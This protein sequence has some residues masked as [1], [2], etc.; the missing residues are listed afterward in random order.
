MNATANESHQTTSAQWIAQQI[1]KPIVML[2]QRY[3]D[4][5]SADEYNDSKAAI[6]KSSLCHRNCA[7]GLS[8]SDRPPGVSVLLLKPSVPKD[9][10]T[11][12]G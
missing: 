3:P 8:A 12:Q 4:R 2:R 7:A 10:L 11:L 5:R 9:C 1:G 6:N